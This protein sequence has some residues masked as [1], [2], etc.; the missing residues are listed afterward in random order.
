MLIID[1]HKKL[2]L[3]LLFAVYSDRELASILGFKGG[4][5]ALLFYG[6]DRFSVDLD[7]D[8]LDPAMADKVFTHL[9]KIAGAH[10]VI[11][12]KS[13]KRN[14]LLLVV[15]Y[16]LLDQNI[17]L[18]VSTRDFGSKFTVLNYLGI[19]MK[20]M[21]KEDMFAH[22]LAAMSE[23]IGSAN[24]DIYDVNYF[25]KNNWPLNEK[26][27][28]K[29]VGKDL[30]GFLEKTA[31]QVE[32]VKEN[33]ILDGIGELLDNKAKARVKKQLTKDTAGRLRILKESLTPLH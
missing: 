23:R 18:E 26:M 1:K 24:R 11:K 22:K 32:S 14:T 20:V 15:S 8:L 3:D 19:P 10:G 7:F 17:K 13:K 12:E 33:K 5:A 31:V 30:K 21:V 27:L 6:L 2:L 28:V 9:E 16:G 4:T 29:R 25:L